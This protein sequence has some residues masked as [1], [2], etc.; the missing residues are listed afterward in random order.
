M[1]GDLQQNR[2]RTLEQRLQ[3]RA[4]EISLLKEMSLFL[5]SSHEKTLEL[6]AYRMGVLTSA[7][8]V[9]V[10]LIDKTSSRLRF[11]S[12]YNLSEKYLEMVRNKFEVSV[13]SAPCGRAVTD[14]VPYVVNDVNQ[15]PMFAMWRDVTAMLGY[16]SYVAMPLFVADRII[17][18]VDVFFGEVRHFSDDELNLMTVLSNAGALAIEHALLIEKIA[19]I[20]IVDEDTGAFNCRYFHKALKNEVER[21]ARYKQ[22][23]AIIM[24]KVTGAQT[25]KGEELRLFVSEL[26]NKTRGTDV[27]FRY[28]EDVLCLMLTHTG[29]NPAVISRLSNSFNEVFGNEW[30]MSLGI[31]CMPEDGDTPEMLI[32]KASGYPD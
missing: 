19:D 10:Y 6:F 8:F 12:G 20:S 3:Q 18:A 13:E 31:A 11:V 7:K 15:D 29:C 16:S 26:R 1:S 25:L 30:K 32:S 9:R 24:I 28:D 2:I 23:L 4:R 27:L 21:A 14:K 22:N 5:T 17:G